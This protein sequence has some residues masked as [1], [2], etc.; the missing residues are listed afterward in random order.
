MQY[1]NNESTLK[2]IVPEFVKATNEILDVYEK[3]P[4]QFTLKDEFSMVLMRIYQQFMLDAFPSAPL[5]VHHQR[6]ISFAILARSILDIIIQLTWILSLDD[7]KK[8]KAI[9]CFLEF[10][11]IYLDARGKHQYQ[12]QGLIDKNYS[13]RGAAIAVGIDREILN[14]PVK[15][16]WTTKDDSVVEVDDTELKLTVFDYLSKITHWNPRFLTELVGVNKNKHVGYTDEYLR[17]C[18]IALPT[19]ISCAVMFAEIFCG[20]FFED[21]DNQLKRLQK[22]K[23]DFDKL[24]ADLINNPQAD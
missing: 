12:W 13:S 7:A 11:G 9:K 19:F 8:Q 17:M 2:G 4:L 20:H 14:F 23:A 21:K 1:A 24:F 10:E 3:F 18:I 22:I 6:F 5:L 16:I 15:K